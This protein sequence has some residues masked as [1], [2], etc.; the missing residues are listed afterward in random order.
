MSPWP[1]PVKT[2]VLP[3]KLTDP[4]VAYTN[5][6]TEGET[7]VPLIGQSPTIG[8]IVRRSTNHYK[9]STAFKIDDSLLVDVLL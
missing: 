7:F 6:A 1:I 5:Q 4:D 2:E 9:N 8:K 3:E